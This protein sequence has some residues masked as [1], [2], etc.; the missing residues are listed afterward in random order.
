ML[1][2]P[3]PEVSRHCEKLQTADA[4]NSTACQTGT[5][6]A[7]ARSADGSVVN[8]RGADTRHG[9]GARRLRICMGTLVAVEATALSTAAATAAVEAAFATIAAIEHRLHPRRPASDLARINDA[10]P[11]A[12]VAVHP[13][14]CELLA[15]AHQLNTL[16]AGAFDPCLPTQ[17]GRMPDV[18]TTAGHE[19]LCHQKVALD[20]GGFAKGY[21]VDCAVETLLSHGCTAGLVNAGGDLR[22]F[23]TQAEPILLREPDGTL[24][25]VPLSNAAL[26]VSDASSTSRPPEHRGYYLRTATRVEIPPATNYAAVIA[27]QAVWADALAKCVLLCPAEVA[28]RALQTFGA[29]QLVSVSAA[30]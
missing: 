3:A 23:G 9:S 12:P 24:A 10:S 7:D 20:F 17:P 25:E 29:R 15:L 28:A 2:I 8:G 30:A 11:L 26:A 19:V 21:A 13:S 27:R 16:T 1:R 4:Q 18:L 14:T 6:P 22:V 5:R